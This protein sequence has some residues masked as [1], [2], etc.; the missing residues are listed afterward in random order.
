MGSIIYIKNKLIKQMVYR[1]RML[2]FINVNEKNIT[3]D[4]IYGSYF[5]VILNKML[6]ESAEVDLAIKQLLKTLKRNDKKVNR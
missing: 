5:S 6:G 3:T 4:E 2:G 1:L